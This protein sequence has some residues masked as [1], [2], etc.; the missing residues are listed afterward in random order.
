MASR[1]YSWMQGRSNHSAV[2]IESSK[3]S[4]GIPNSGFIPWFSATNPCP[5]T[6][7]TKHRGSEFRHPILDSG[8]GSRNPSRNLAQTQF[9]K[10]TK[11]LSQ[12]LVRR[13]Q[14]Q[15]PTCS[16]T[17]FPKPDSCHFV[18]PWQFLKPANPA[19]IPGTRFPRNLHQP[20]LKPHHLQVTA[21]KKATSATCNIPPDLRYVRNRTRHPKPR[22]PPNLPLPREPSEP[23]PM[24]ES[25]PNS[26]GPPQATLE[27]ILRAETPKAYC[28][29]GTTSEKELECIR[30]YDLIYLICSYVSLDVDRVCRLSSLSSCVRPVNLYPKNSWNIAPCHMFWPQRPS[31]GS[32]ILSPSTW[33]EVEHKSS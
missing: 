17:W 24:C 2:I 26:R 23:N 8:S 30:C 21:G 11:H 32:I 12:N 1:N 31:C 5:E 22:E 28:C 25:V 13:T 27:A 33:T 3:S 16:A 4:G 19:Q 15:E 7:N 20:P 10:F 6:P 18:A 9:T 29:C 14:F